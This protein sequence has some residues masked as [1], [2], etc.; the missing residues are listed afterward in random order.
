MGRFLLSATVRQGTPFSH[1]CVSSLMMRGF[2]CC[3]TE[4]SSRFPLVVK[5]V[6]F[7]WALG[8]G[9]ISR[10]LLEMTLTHSDFSPSKMPEIVVSLERYLIAPPMYC[11]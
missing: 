2:L 4:V 6:G 9:L 7:L 10:S 11:T 1:S 3:S 8:R 5:S